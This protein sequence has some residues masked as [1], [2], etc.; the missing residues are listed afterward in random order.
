MKGQAPS[1]DGVVWDSDEELNGEQV[2]V[3]C[4]VDILNK[5]SGKWEHAIVA[6]T[7][8]DQALIKQEELGNDMNRWVQF[9]SDDMAP[10][11]TY[12]QSNSYKR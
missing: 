6:F 7:V 10:F 2:E 3:G 11:G 1:Y 12:V 8:K 4:M 5:T 9:D